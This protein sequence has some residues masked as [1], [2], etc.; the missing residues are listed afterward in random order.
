ML[1]VMPMPP[2]RPNRL[3]ADEPTG[4]ADELLGRGHAAAPLSQ[5]RRV[6]LDRGQQGHG[7]RLLGM[8]DHV[9]HAVLQRLEPADRHAELLTGL[10]V[11]EGRCVEC[12]HAAD[13]FCTDCRDGAIDRH[14]QQRIT[15]SSTPITDSA[16][17]V[18]FEGDLRG[19]RP[20]VGGNT[21]PDTPCSA[22]LTKNSV[23]PWGC[24]ASRWSA[25]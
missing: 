25:P 8:H 7:P 15:V 1:F 21:R 17:M 16:L 22:G 2:C 6:D 19:A 10:E 14:L 4:A 5:V 23:M 20:V 24:P 3:L 18:T 13:R 11:F 12:V 9:D